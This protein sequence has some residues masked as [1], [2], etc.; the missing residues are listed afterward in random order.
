MARLREPRHG[1]VT[2]NTDDGGVVRPAGGRQRRRVAGLAVLVT[3]ALPITGT[4]I[5]RAQEEY[6]STRDAEARA[7]RAAAAEDGVAVAAMG[8]AF[9][10]VY[11]DIRGGGLPDPEPR[12]R[13]EPLLTLAFDGALDA[14]GH[15]RDRAIRRAPGDKPPFVDGDL[16]SSLF[17]GATDCQAGAVTLGRH[18]AG[19]VLHYRYAQGT[20]QMGW[21]DRLTL[22]RTDDGWRI[23]D[24]VYGGSWD[25]AS[26]GSLRSAIEAAAAEDAGLTPPD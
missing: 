7:A 1:Q 5:A 16:F 21:T 10:A 23:D 2:R 20:T 12:M 11:P 3:L 19:V 24:V 25:F 18:T 13:L 4:G 8:A 9:C 17:E 15:L 14:A 22:L 6:G 26:R